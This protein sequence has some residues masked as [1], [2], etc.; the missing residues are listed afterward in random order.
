[1]D[2]PLKILLILDGCSVRSGEKK[3]NKSGVFLVIFILLLGIAVVPTGP[4]Y[5]ATQIEPSSSVNTAALADTGTLKIVVAEDTYVANATNA[6]T[7]FDGIGSVVTGVANIGV[8]SAARGWFKFDLTHLPQEFSITRATFNTYL[9][10]EYQSDDK[11][12]GIYYCNDD[13]WDSSVITWNNAPTFSATPSD[14]ID[15]P[16]SPSM[17]EEDKWYTW[18][19][20]NDVRTSLSTGDMI[21]T[22][23]MKQVD[24]SGTEQTF[25][26]WRESET[27][28]D[29][30]AVLEIEY[31]S[32]TTSNPTVDGIATGPML[33]YIKSDAPELGWTFSDPDSNDFQRDYDVEIWNDA[34]YSD[35]LLWGRGYE[36]ISTVHNSFGDGVDGNLHPF[37]V[38]DEV[39]LQMKYLNTEL[40]E[41]GIVDKLY[42]TA[43]NETGHIQVENLEISM[44]MVTDSGALTTNFES[45]FD[46]VIPTVVLSA[47]TYDVDVIDGVI[48]IDIANIFMVNE[49]WNLVIQVRLMDNTG[50]IIS[51]NRTTTGGPGFVAGKVGTGAYVSPTAT[52]ANTRTYDLRL[53]MLTQPV[54]DGSTGGVNYFPF[55]T[56]IGYSGRFQLKYN[57]SYVNRKGYLDRAYM[58]V[59]EFTGDVVFENFTVRLVETPVLGP[60]SNGTWTE[61]YGGAIAY[62][63]LDENIYTV[64]NLGGCIVIDFD[65]SF[66]YTNTH[67]LLIDLQWDSLVSGLVR[68][69]NKNTGAPSYRAFDV[70]WGGHTEGNDTAGYDLMLDFVNDDDSVNV[71]GGITLVNGTDYYWRVRTC[72]STGIWSD[73]VTQSFTYQIL[74]SLPTF[75]TPVV[76]PA[77]AYIGQT[78]TVTLNVTHSTG[79][80]SVILEMESTGYDMTADGDT[81]SFSFTPSTAATYNFTILMQSNADTWANVTGSFVVYPAGAGGVDMTMLL[82]II[83]VVAVVIIIIVI[84]RK[85]KK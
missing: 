38:Q 19:V 4:T 85:K 75:T 64:K 2:T 31:T 68:V 3:M 65:N 14:V 20:T 53:G 28:I 36:M 40:S 44:A 17:L 7:N 83:G 33:D 62:S 58:R 59:N 69:N 1:M 74:T 66:Y 25:K 11:P 30:C 23:V 73:W 39:R 26:A 43:R 45:N 50:E 34:T 47:D 67:D 9:F 41:S 56:D 70:E 77:L 48:E 18:E 76:T 81:Y 60:I 72:D 29:Y 16:A 42:L 10:S 82:I 63:V 13:S 32:P 55:G 21:L 79:I 22:E 51:L 52:Y 12:L 46:G 71:E 49:N 57:Q 54:W 61:N 35:T 78:I 27:L 84:I 5:S 80:N 8:T 15:S 37:G 6:D 24:E